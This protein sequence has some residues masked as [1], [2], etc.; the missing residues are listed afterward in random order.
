MWE[1]QIETEFVLL[2]YTIVT[3]PDDR[4][5]LDLGARGAGTAVWSTSGHHNAALCYQAMGFNWY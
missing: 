3:P 1:C 2:L 4:S 5:F